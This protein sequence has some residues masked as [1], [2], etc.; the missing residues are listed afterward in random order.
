MRF[1]LLLLALFF[2]HAA[3]AAPTGYLND[4][5]QAKCYD[6]SNTAVTCDPSGANPGQDGRFGRDAAATAGKLAKTGAGSSGFDYTKVCMSGEL[7]GQGS[8][9]ASPAQGSGT[10]QWACTKD[11]VTNL[12][13]SMDYSDQKYNWT[14]ASVTYPAAMNATN[15]CG[16]TD[17]R[18][19]TRRELL[20]LIYL[21]SA[22][23]T[24]IDNTYFPSAF[25]G[26]HWSSDSY[27][28]DSTQAWVVNFELGYTGSATS[29]YIKETDTYWIRLVR[30]AP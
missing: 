1:P 21:N 2:G 17:W 7:A 18:L 27:A 14:Y 11:N 22:T 19:P 24:L 15:R 26:S 10:N 5:G 16:G 4:T 20:S 25:R 8:C 23:D 3:D 13:W 28:G 29:S 6:A 30:D 9:P 12:I